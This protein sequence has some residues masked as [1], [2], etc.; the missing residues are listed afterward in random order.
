M[1]QPYQSNDAN[2]TRLDSSF[3]RGTAEVGLRDIDRDRCPDY[4]AACAG[5]TREE[6]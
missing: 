1:W 4:P 6:G 3:L 5:E 2:L